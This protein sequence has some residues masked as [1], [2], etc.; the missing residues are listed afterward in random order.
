MRINVNDFLVG[1]GGGTFLVYITAQGSILT[2]SLISGV[3]IGLLNMELNKK[4]QRKR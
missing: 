1:F 4:K 2:A 3:L